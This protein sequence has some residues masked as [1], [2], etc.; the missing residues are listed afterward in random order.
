MNEDGNFWDLV[1]KV[2]FKEGKVVILRIG[3]VSELFSMLPVSQSGEVACKEVFI[4]D[5]GQKI[6][7]V[8]IGKD[9]A[10]TILFGVDEVKEDVKIDKIVIGN[11]TLY[12]NGDF[13]K[14]N[15][16]HEENNVVG[17][18]VLNE[19]FGKEVENVSLFFIN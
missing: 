1:A 10:I 11:V 7:N 13:Q 12:W 9:S 15:E 18:G 17:D 16:K 5:F 2:N 14:T 8:V 6:K 19:V 4:K 3:E